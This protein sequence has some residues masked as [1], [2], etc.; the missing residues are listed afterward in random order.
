MRMPLDTDQFYVRG[1]I[2]GLAEAFGPADGMFDIIRRFA[3]VAEGETYTAIARALEKRAG[4]N[5][6]E[7]LISLL[8]N[9]VRGPA[10][11]DETWWLREEE[12][13]RGAGLRDFHGGPFSSYLNSVRGAALMALMR[14][15]DH[16]GDEGLRRKWILLEFVAKE[17]STALRAGAVEELYYLLDDD[18]ERVLSTFERVLEG[19]PALL[20]S[21]YTDE[22]LYYAFFKNYL[23]MKPYIVAMMEQ[24]PENIQQRGA[25]LACIAAI[26]L[27]ALE[28]EEAQSHAAALAET[29]ITGLVS[30]RRGAARIYAFNLPKGCDPCVVGLT[31]LL[32]DEDE[33]IQRLI[34]G[35]FRSMR[36]EHIFALRGFIDSYAKSRALRR[37][38]HE[39][40]EYLW[41]HGPVDPVWA[42]SIVGLVL[43][44][45]YSNLSELIFVGAEELIR[46]V[47][48]VYT[49]PT[50][51]DSTRERAMDLFDRLMEKFLRPAQK[52]LG[53][54]DRK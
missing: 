43:D 39:F 34:G 50:V 1:L 49:D 16:M 27:S 53:E 28:S 20:G 30:W 26:S 5:I 18:R 6:P 8:E 31:R 2:S 48:R 52:I 9:Y 32:D 44:I 40:T 11:D 36:D 45:A 37:G 46:V 33:Q 41:K 25:E 29:V 17:E 38:L 22:F 4:D 54:W 14:T 23:R 3:P 51:E 10:N 21:H 7:D 42:L 24:D 19:H 15:F 35:T 47:L 13:P 12:R